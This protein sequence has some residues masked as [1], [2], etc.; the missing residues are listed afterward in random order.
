MGGR[1]RKEEGYI[2]L[3]NKDDR[4]NRHWD[5]KNSRIKEILG[6]LRYQSVSFGIE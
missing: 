5:R 6:V 1:G 4:E 3:G 2:Y